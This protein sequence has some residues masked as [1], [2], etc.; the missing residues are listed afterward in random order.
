M[1]NS[2]LEWKTWACS[3][4]DLTSNIMPGYLFPG[5]PLPLPLPPAAGGLPELPYLNLALLLHE[6][7]RASLEKIC[8]SGEMQRI[9]SGRMYTLVPRS[10][11]PTKIRQ[12]IEG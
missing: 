5:I 2:V 4:R 11:G 9:I 6:V 1:R 7:P 8:G 10:T 12:R 3:G